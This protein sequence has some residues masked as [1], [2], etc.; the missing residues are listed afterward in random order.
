MAYILDGLVIIIF[1][2]AIWMGYRRGFFKSIIQLVGCVAA[3]LIASGL[4]T[5]V[6][7]GVYDQFISKS[8]QNQ[9]ESRIEEA[10]S[11]TVETALGG[12]LDDLP[13]SVSNV[14]A[15]FDIGSGEKLKDRIQGSLDGTAA[16]IA[17]AIEDK[18][19]RPAAVSLLKIVIFFVLFIILLILVGIAASIVGKVFKLPILR[20]TDGLLGAVLGAAQGVVLVL[21]VVSVI[22][23]I[24]SASK[25]DGK[26]TRAAVNDTLIVKSVEKINPITNRFYSMFGARAL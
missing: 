15:M 14:L 18:V 16:Q 7:S 9:I 26:I 24:A 23:L 21:A 6:A 10:S 17:R 13:D 22:S 8:V 1:M 4:S 20:Q 2:L 3:A 5:P 11:E 12:V 19:I 25:P